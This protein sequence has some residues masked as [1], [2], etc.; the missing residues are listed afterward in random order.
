M[1]FKK[2]KI[3]NVR[4]V[5]KMFE[6]WRVKIDTMYERAFKFCKFSYKALANYQLS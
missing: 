1:F 4:G 5:I 6:D 2:M 3:I